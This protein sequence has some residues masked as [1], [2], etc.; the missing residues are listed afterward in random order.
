LYDAGRRV[1]LLNV[2]LPPQIGQTF[3]ANLI[4]LFTRT[5][6]LMSAKNARLFLF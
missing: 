1:S 6:N 5:F 2:T 4:E 3:L